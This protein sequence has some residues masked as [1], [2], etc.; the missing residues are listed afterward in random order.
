MIYL[1]DMSVFLK[2]QKGSILRGVLCG[3]SLLIA[4]GIGISTWS[5]FDE[6]KQQIEKNRI[7]I[8]EYNFELNKLNQ[9]IENFTGD[10]PVETYSVKPVCSKIAELQTQY[11]SYETYS[12]VSQITEDA[13]RISG[14]LNDYI[15]ASQSEAPWFNDVMTKYEWS[16]EMREESLVK[17][18]PVI[19]VCRDK[20]TADIYGVTTGVYD[21]DT[22]RVDDLTVYCSKKGD[23]VLDAGS[24]ESSEGTGEMVEDLI[25]ETDKAMGDG[26]LNTQEEIDAAVSALEEKESQE[27][28]V[29]VSPSPSVE[30]E[31]PEAVDNVDNSVDSSQAVPSASP[32]GTKN[33]GKLSNDEILSSVLKGGN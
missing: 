17:K 33:T 2:T 11:G 24:E 4:A 20:Q 13:K 15:D 18:V 23:Y 6:T 7:S 1:D 26:V 3:V 27:G 14:E 32:H 5:S 16:F 19:W 30:L 25:N 8:S 12:S 29:T 22:S 28:N 10:E 21:A 9:A 31:N